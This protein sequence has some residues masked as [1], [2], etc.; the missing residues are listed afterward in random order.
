VTPGSFAIQSH[1]EAG[2]SVV[3]AS[4]DIDLSNG[5]AFEARL[6]RAVEDAERGI[7]VDLSNATF[8][9]STA[10]NAL[11]RCFERQR[12]KLQRLSLVSTDS[13]V[14]ALL[15]VTRLDRILEV[16]PTREGA[17]ARVRED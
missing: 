4:G 7:V 9:D 10:L 8:M 17:L 3:T 1:V 11:V 13:R 15:E 5:A 16:Y 6:A 12:A 14:T 2:T